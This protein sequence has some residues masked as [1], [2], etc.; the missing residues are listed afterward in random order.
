ML[1]AL[2]KTQRLLWGQ[3]DR[4]SLWRNEEAP[5]H[6]CVVSAN[7]KPVDCTPGLA[8]PS[9]EAW[10]QLLAQRNGGVFPCRSG[11]TAATVI[12]WRP[13]GKPA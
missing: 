8:S 7:F 10:P 5:E 11:K 12:I 3:L 2:P 4:Q 13:S 1:T 6:Y 9:A